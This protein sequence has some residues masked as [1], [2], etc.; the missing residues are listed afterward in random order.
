MSI[1]NRIASVSLLL[2]DPFFSIWSPADRLTDCDTQS[3][4]GKEIPIRGYLT[5]GDRTYCFMGKDPKFPVLPQSELKITPTQTIYQ[6]ENEVAALE[7]C[8]STNL[9]LTKLQKISEPVTIISTKASIKT[10]DKMRVS[11]QFSDKICQDS[12]AKETINWSVVQ[13]KAE[14]IAWMGKEQ[15]TPLNSSGDLV[16][17]DW[18][19]F[20]LASANAADA[21]YYKNLEMLEFTYTAA[22][23]SFL[24]AYDDM[25]AINYFGQAENA[26]WKEQYPTMIALL[27]HYLTEI[28]QNLASCRRIDEQIQQASLKAGGE[29]LDLIT[30]MAYRQAI[31]AHKLIRDEKGEVIF[32]SKECSSNGCIGTVDVSYPSIPLFLLYQPELVKGMLRPIY[33]FASLPVWEYEFA[34][35]DVGRYPYATGQVYGFKEVPAA[36][37]GT[38]LSRKGTV[39]DLYALPAGQEIYTEKYQMPIEECGNMLAMSAAVYLIEGDADFFTEHLEQ[40]LIWADYLFKHGQDPENQLCTDDFAGHLAHN[41]NL[42]LK[43][44]T[45]LALFGKALEQLQLPRAAELSKKAKKMAAIWQEQASEQNSTKLAFD[46][47]GSWSMKYNIVWDKLFEL[48]MFTDEVYR[49]E[50]TVYLE[51]QNEFGTPLDNRATYTK[52]DWIMWSAAL[53]DDPE[54][55]EMLIAPLRRYLEKTNSRVPFSDWYDTVSADVMNFKNRTVVGAMFMPLLKEKLREEV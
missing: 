1:I 41:V 22:E 31:C 9:D 2:S 15:Q 14:K 20:Y 6:F 26:L 33:R 50:I 34:P 44:I 8:F 28:Q 48:G 47:H 37:N 19:Y 36:T 21:T 46:Q 55:V 45:S 39:V 53:T 49:R 23:H 32:L 17:I 5:V 11:W 7:V 27:Q 40:N 24:A 10:A 13:T 42:S 51:K 4:T 12:D 35:H 30:T 18:G 54:Q 29:T 52:A 3:W 38:H 25:H 43:A 16:D